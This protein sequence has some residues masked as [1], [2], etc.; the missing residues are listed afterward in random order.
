MISILT[1]GKSMVIY[2]DIHSK[3]QNLAKRQRE[4]SL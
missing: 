3:F 1:K 4:I 2:I